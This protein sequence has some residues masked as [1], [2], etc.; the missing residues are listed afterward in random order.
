MMVVLVQWWLGLDEEVVVVR[1]RGGQTAKK[2]KWFD[3]SGGD[4]RVWLL[5]VD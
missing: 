3:E 5:L 1:Y 2:D 4:E